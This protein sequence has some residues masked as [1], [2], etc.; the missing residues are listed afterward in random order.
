M[1]IGS[2]RRILPPFTRLEPRTRRVI[3][4]SLRKLT[5][6]GGGSPP[7][8]GGAPTWA[9]AAATSASMPA[10]AISIVPVKRHMA[11]TSAIT[12][13]ITQ[14]YQKVNL[15]PKKLGYISD[16]KKVLSLDV[17]VL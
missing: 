9:G 6:T 15:A 3:L 10:T 13:L 8:L 17:A 11:E 7:P 12:A 2:E 16:S 14:T 5:L 4:V 1:M